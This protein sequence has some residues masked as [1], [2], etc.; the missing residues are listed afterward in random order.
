MARKRKAKELKLDV[1]EDGRERFTENQEPD[2]SS[3]RWGST[4]PT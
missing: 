1:S 4:S 2:V 3:R